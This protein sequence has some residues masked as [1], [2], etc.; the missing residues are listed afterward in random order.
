M[1]FFFPAIVTERAYGATMGR[2]PELSPAEQ[3]EGLR[4]ARD[5]YTA[6]ADR[7]H[8]TALAPSE[9]QESHRARE[10]EARRLAAAYGN[11]FDIQSALIAPAR[12]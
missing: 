7:I 8:E 5:Y 1:T 10:Q 12:P 2:Q 9:S 6:L 11:S 3:L 4:K